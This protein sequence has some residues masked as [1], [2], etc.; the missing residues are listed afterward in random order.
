MCTLKGIRKDSSGTH[1]GVERFVK[2]FDGGL[3]ENLLGQALGFLR[4]LCGVVM[5]F[6]PLLENLLCQA[7]G[8]FPGVVKV[9]FVVRWVAELA[10]EPLELRVTLP[11]RTSRTSRSLLSTLVIRGIGTAGRAARRIVSYQESIGTNL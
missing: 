8:A 6:G 3:L 7:L 11:Q 5:A 1:L 10:M 4:L 9:T 2:F